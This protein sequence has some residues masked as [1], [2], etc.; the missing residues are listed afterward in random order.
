MIIEEQFKVERNGV[1]GVALYADFNGSDLCTSIIG[2]NGRNIIAPWNWEGEA[3]SPTDPAATPDMEWRQ[4][5]EGDQ[6][7]TWQNSLIHGWAGWDGKDKRLDWL[8]GTPENLATM[9]ERGK[10]RVGQSI[11]VPHEIPGVGVAE[12][13]M[14]AADVTQTFSILLRFPVPEAAKQAEKLARIW[15]EPSP[16][17]P[18]MRDGGGGLYLSTKSANHEIFGARSGKATLGYDSGNLDADYKMATGGWIRQHVIT[19]PF[20]HGFWNPN[21]EV[22]IVCWPISKRRAREIGSSD[23]D[24][25]R[26]IF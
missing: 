16:Y 24:G 6:T 9:Y 1:R 8:D 2:A 22:L 21:P 26:M 11:M 12:Q 13:T 25:R 20:S 7:F 10:G 19:N 4:V 5:L 3:N 18:Q 14:E 23:L 15:Q 17:R